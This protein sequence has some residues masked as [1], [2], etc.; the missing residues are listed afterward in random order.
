[1]SEVRFMSW[2]IKPAKSLPVVLRD[3]LETSSLPYLVYIGQGD[4]IDR[5]IREIFRFRSHCDRSWYLDKGKKSQCPSR[6][7][8]CHFVRQT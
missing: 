5:P 6:M 3:V 4:Q 8:T 7:S 1:M 2:N